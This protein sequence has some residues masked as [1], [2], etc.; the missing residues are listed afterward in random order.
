MTGE[1]WFLVVADYG[2]GTR[3]MDSFDDN[4][5]ALQAYAEAESRHRTSKSVEVVL[6]AS[7]D[8]TSLQRSYPHLFNETRQTSKRQALDMLERPAYA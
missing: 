3:H 5:E 8:E 7:E 6:I 2:T 4:D 1:T